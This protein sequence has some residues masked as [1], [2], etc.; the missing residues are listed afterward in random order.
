MVTWR[1]RV[2]R[3][4][5]LLGATRI[6]PLPQVAAVWLYGPRFSESEGARHGHATCVRAAARTCA[7][8]SAGRGRS[9]GWAY[10]KADRVPH[11]F[12][13]FYDTVVL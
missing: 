8:G 1:A 6:A 13:N 4:I 9:R 10:T 12:A 2:R 3:E 7:G 11:E 5:H